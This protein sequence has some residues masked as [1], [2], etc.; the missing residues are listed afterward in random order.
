M[1]ARY[2]KLILATLAATTVTGA[3]A[4]YHPGDHAPP[5]YDSR[6]S[7]FRAA[8]PM[9]VFIDVA[10]PADRRSRS[11]D[12]FENRTLYTLE[13]NLPSY[14][15]IVHDRRYADMVVQAR[16]TD[17]SLNFRVV[18]VDREDKK[19]GKKYRYTGGR[20][21]HHVRAF[22]TEVKEKGEAYASYSVRVSLRGEGREQDH[23]RLRAAE[24]FR[25]G[26]DLT[27][28]TNCGTVPTQHYPSKGVAELFAKASPAYR[29]EVV[30]EIR[31]EAAD[32]LGKALAKKVRN[33]TDQYY[34]GLAVRFSQTHRHD[35]PPRYSE[36]NYEQSRGDDYG[37][38]IEYGHHDPRR[39][40]DTD[41]SDEDLGAAVLIVAGLAILAASSGN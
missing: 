15:Q 30:R 25:Y 9:K 11:V 1:T 7:N 22:Y 3:A 20:C 8:H 12:G 35:N 2:K 24:D 41:T 33:R 17:Y 29:E 5:V 10:T 37:W 14:V 27:A 34:T 32:D 28:Q 31:Q 19:Y 4:A 23:L 6:D 36:G 40:S 16:Q 18:D 39:A 13:R 26:K 21:G 38:R